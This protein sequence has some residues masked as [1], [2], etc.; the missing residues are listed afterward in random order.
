MTEQEHLLA[1]L[2]EEC[3]EIQQHV[4]KALRFGIDDTDPT[5]P[6][7]ATERELIVAELS[8][9]YAV[10]ELLTDRLILPSSGYNHQAIQRKK[11]K[12]RKFFKYARERGALSLQT[13]SE[14]K[15][16]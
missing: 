16:Q 10:V 14:G 5:I 12:V 2:A 7:A 3:A 15:E 6:D 9:L 1:C 11:D 13:V 8:D 4:G